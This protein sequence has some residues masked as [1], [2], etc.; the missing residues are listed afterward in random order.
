MMNS[1]ARALAPRS[2]AVMGASDNPHKVGGRPVAY[3]KQYGFQGA[4]YPVNPVRAEVQGL[5]AY[6][7]LADLPEVPDL[8]VVAVGGEEGVRMVEQAAAA[9]VAV[10]VVMAS[11]YAETG[12]DGRRQQAR[13]LAAAQA[14]GMRLVGPN[15][16]GLANFATGAIANFATIFHE[17][18]SSDGALAIVGQSGAATQSIYALAYARGIHARYVL[19]TGNEADVTVAELFGAVVPDPGIRAVVLYLESITRTDQL[20]EAAALARARGLPVIAIK[21]GRSASGQ[22]A[23]SSHTGALA[24]EDR[25]VD[26]FFARHGIVRVVDPYEAISLVPLLMQAVRPAGDSLVAISNSGASCVM[27]AD[28]ADEHGV[29]LMA[30]S[31]AARTR[32]DAALPQFVASTNPIDLTGA[33]LTDRK[34]FAEVLD[35]LATEARPDLLL[36]AFPVAGAGYDV[37]GYA[38]DL[39]AF[40]SRCAT[41]VAVAAPQASVREPFAGY[42][43]AT[44]DR[45]LE[46]LQ[47]LKRF[48]D[49]CAGQREVAPPAR[50]PVEVALPAP[51]GG[52]FMSEAQ[53]L[54]VLAQAGLPTVEHIVCR[55]QDE[56]IAAF[57]KLGPRVVVKACSEEVTHKSEHGLVAVGLSDEAAVVQAFER[58]CA[59]LAALGAASEGILVARMVGG[60]RELALG[61]RTDPVFGPVVMVGD[62]GIYL[63]ALGEFRLLL[64]PFDVAAVEAALAQL[65]IAPLL[66]GVRGE[67]PA[68]IGAFAQM[69]VRLGDAMLAWQDDVASIDINPVKVL[70]RGEGA[71]AIDALIERTVTSG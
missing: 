3:M 59:T 65:R 52:R 55:T 27:M 32:L 64:P 38:R 19:A 48:A 71:V 16:Q 43:L 14:A 24:T 2:V 68:D 22:L 28:A 49:F 41:A 5:T 47:A 34:L 11:G 67:P 40:A 17:Q 53:S 58:Q 13:M 25:V 12:E 51:G 60:G 69:A 18:P 56:A 20:A 9:G 33:L 1:L 70:A 50:A 61:A 37:P 45:E 8:V 46:A 4:I 26:A 54:A 36:L 39:A 23:A 6:A 21:G 29:P 31:D 7:S 35:T 15:C 66:R 10:A 62:G 63:E 42:G 57:R 44:Y 30:F